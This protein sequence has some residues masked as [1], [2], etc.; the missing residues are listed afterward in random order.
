MSSI[1]KR[2]GKYQAQ[3]RK[4]GQTVSKTFT[5]K[6]DAIKWS[7]EQEVLIEQ[8][9]FTSKKESITLSPANAL[10]KRSLKKPQKLQ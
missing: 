10:G 3:V 6:A 5:S 2:R 1:R 8:G 7:K 4:D 9:S